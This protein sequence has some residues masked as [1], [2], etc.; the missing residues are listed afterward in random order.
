MMAERTY[1]A[2]PLTLAMVA[3]LLSG[4]AAL[5]AEED[6]VRLRMTDIEARVIRMERMLENQSI[7]ALAEQ[8]DVLARQAQELRGDIESLQFEFEQSQERQRQQYR[9]LDDRLEAIE[10]RPA[11]SGA[12]AADNGAG[13]STPL[14]AGQ[15]PLPGASDRANYQ[16]AFELLQSGRYDEAAN[17]F[18]QF[19]VSFGD[20]PLADNAQYWLAET[21]YVNRRFSQALPMFQRVL[22]DFPNSRKAPDALLKIGYANYELQNWAAARSFLMRVVEEFGDT[23]A[24]RLA[25][26]RIDRIDSEGR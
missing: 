4:C 8:V 14:S 16:A 18:R 2:L 6:P 22:D 21:A 11:Q 13:G 1:F 26:Q 5:P 17:A 25:Q 15:L 12:A 19:L 9:D 3:L 20:S 7:A 24:A 23:T 10:R